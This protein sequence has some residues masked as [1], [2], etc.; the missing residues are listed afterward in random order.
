MSSYMVKLGEAIFL[1]GGRKQS[2]VATSSAEAEYYSLVM[3]AKETVGVR[4]ILEEAGLGSTNVTSIHSDNQ[5]AIRW[6]CGEKC[7]SSRAKHIE[8]R[9]HFIRDY[10]KKKG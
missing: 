7:E 5:A 10:V 6:A 8:V 9:I 4:R 3:A 1:W 2:S